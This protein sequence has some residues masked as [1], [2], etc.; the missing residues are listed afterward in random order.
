MTAENQG[1]LDEETG[2]IFYSRATYLHSVQTRK[3]ARDNARKKASEKERQRLL[4]LG[5]DAA[6]IDRMLGKTP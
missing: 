5:V 3:R 6:W 1:Y 4:G 2:R